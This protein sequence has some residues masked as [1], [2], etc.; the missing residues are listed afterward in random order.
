MKI[1]EKAIEIVNKNTVQNGTYKGE[2]C[3]I[4][5]IDEEGFPTASVITPSKSEGLLWIT[6]GTIFTDNRAKRSIANNH[7]CVCFCSNEYCV[8]LVGEI[9]VIT[10]ND[11]KNTM[12]YDGLSYHFTGPSDPNYCVL[13]FNTKRY[14]LFID[15]E[16]ASGTL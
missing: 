7:A 10:D 8:N 6:F 15:G 2:S 3:V 9:E 12:W 13:R 16:D 1:I 4:C 5:L 11:V 14:K